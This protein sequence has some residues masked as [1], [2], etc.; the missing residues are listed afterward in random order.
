MSKPLDE[1]DFVQQ[2]VLENLTSEVFGK[3][4]PPKDWA[5]VG[6][7]V[8]HECIRREMQHML[9]SVDQLSRR[10]ETNTIQAWQAV[11]FCEWYVDIFEPFINVHH[12]AE[13]EIYFPWLAT[14]AEI[15]D[16][17]FSKDHIELVDLLTDI[18]SVCRK[19]IEKEGIDCKNEIE[20]LR[21]KMHKFVPDMNS[22]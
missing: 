12:D 1:N 22:K 6:L 5:D 2:F 8:P 18:G 7:L 9:K 13:E 14:K 19:V 17:K 10:L 4:N 20:D 21:S 3:D 11:Y 15:P 16:K